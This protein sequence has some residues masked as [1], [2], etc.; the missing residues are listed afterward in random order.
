MIAVELVRPGE[1]AVREVPVPTPGPGELL[2]RVES[3]LTCGTDL[4]TF[5]RGHP[6]ISLPAPMGH[7]AS[8]VVAAV[9]AGVNGFREG[10]AIACVPTVPCGTC[11][12]C[13]RGRD[14]L[15]THAVG[16]MNFGAFADYMLLPAHVVA[17]GAFPRPAGMSADE[18]AALEPLACVVHGAHRL[19]LARAEHVVILGDGPI[20]LL[21]LQVARLRGARHIFLAGHHSER[22]AVA[23]ELGASFVFDS[24]GAALRA[25][26]ADFT[27]GTFA[28]VVV[29]CAGTAD[30]WSTA[31][32]LAGTA[33]EVMLF[34]GR[35]SG[36][37]AAFDTY[38]IHYEEIDIKGA[39]HYGPR[40]VREA[41]DLLTRHEVQIA[42][43]VTHR[44]PLTR[45][46]EAL[47]LALERRALKVAVE[48]G[49]SR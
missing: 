17:G 43:L 35:P 2:L 12:L 21:F 32:T 19:A 22:L 33:G 39:F 14:S 49:A 5:R 34:A 30:A 26:I 28:D 42:P 31:P 27:N 37:L 9:G 48:P 10:D 41:L 4:K 8:G 15:C 38:R 25:A 16:R 36:E 24:N 7:E 46:D 18:A 3:A 44:R 29:E 45:F 13:R 1:I 6:R 40:D 20:A 23:R 11:R 47:Q